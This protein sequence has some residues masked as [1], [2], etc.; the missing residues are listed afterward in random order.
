MGSSIKHISRW[1]PV[2]RFPSLFRGATGW[3][4]STRRMHTFRSRCIRTTVA[5]CS[6][7]WTGWS[8]SFGRFVLASP[9]LRRPSPGSWLLS[10]SF[11][12]VWRSG[13]TITSTIG[14]FLPRPHQEALQARDTVLSLCCRVWIVI[15]P[16][17]SVLDRCQTVIYLGM[18]IIS[19]SLRAFPSPERVVTL[20]AQIE[21]FLSSRGQSV[22]SWQSF[23]GRLSLCHLVPSS[24]LRMRSL[25]LFVRQQWDSLDESVVIQWSPEV[26]FDLAWWSDAS[27]VSLLP[28]QPDVLFWSD[29]SDQGWGRTTSI[30]LFRASG[31]RRRSATPSTSG[32]CE[33]FAW[34]CA[35]SLLC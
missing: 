32:S 15:N 34:G 25:E 22:V 20:L 29:A 13:C 30:G 35:T 9:Q 3:S 24:P 8:T 2:S 33:R 10:H 11:S 12:I 28:L 16:Q 27:G 31:L 5:S 6:S 14:S 26:P 23:L 4:P 7:W 19:P 21:E 18:V 17:K 1:R